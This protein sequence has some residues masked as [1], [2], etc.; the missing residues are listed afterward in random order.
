M[1]YEITGKLVT[2]FDI[3]QRTETFKTREFVIEKSEDIG[4]RVITNYVK[5]QCVQD[6][7]AM[8]DRFNIGDDVKVQFNIKGT[9]WVKDGRE[10]YITNL[11]AWRMET[12]KLGQTGGND[13]VNYNDMPPPADIVDDLPF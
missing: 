13:S 6:K 7:T 3:V 1:S 8:P 10:N 5:F 4:G 9:K 11:D 2:V 12:V